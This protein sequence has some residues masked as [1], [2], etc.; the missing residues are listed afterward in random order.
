MR[1][2]GKNVA[3][4]FNESF[5]RK[6]DTISPRMAWWLVKVIK[7]CRLRCRNNTAL[8]NYLNR[9]FT[10]LKFAQVTKTH[11]DGTEYPGLEIS[12][13]GGEIMYTEGEDA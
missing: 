8:N 4:E 12:T 6:I 13:K 9:N 11:A 10:G 1:F 5:G 7:N 3:E 2:D